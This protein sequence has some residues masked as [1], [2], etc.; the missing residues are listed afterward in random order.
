MGITI[1]EYQ[2]NGKDYF[3]IVDG[4]TIRSVP[5]E[6]YDSIA[7]DGQ[8]NNYIL[9]TI[10]VDSRPYLHITVPAE[11]IKPDG[12]WWI[13]ETP[14]TFS[15]K[16]RTGPVDTDPIVPAFEGEFYVI[17]RNRSGMDIFGTYINMVAGEGTVVFDKLDLPLGTTR[18]K[19]HPEDYK[20]VQFSGEFEA[21]IV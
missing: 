7:V 17:V 11:H 5:K 13:G 6:P 3:S 15:L 4:A 8:G 20:L 12:T 19:L 14:V 9:K 16:I 21:V 18:I 1:T 10:P 2:E